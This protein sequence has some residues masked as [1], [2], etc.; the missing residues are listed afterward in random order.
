MEKPYFCHYAKC[1][2]ENIDVTAVPPA[3]YKL[4]KGT[5]KIHTPGGCL[6]AVSLLWKNENSTVKIAYTNESLEIP[7]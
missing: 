2:G 5:C 1:K 3:K 4:N 6:V 7:A